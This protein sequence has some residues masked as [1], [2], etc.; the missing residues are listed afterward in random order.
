M[1]EGMQK[2][3]LRE[4]HFLGKWEND[5]L[6]RIKCNAV[7]GILCQLHLAAIVAIATICYNQSSFS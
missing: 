1:V 6:L 4:K 2:V 3:N 7:V 5:L